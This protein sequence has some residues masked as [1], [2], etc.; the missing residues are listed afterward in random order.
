M[1]IEFMSYKLS[2]EVEFGNIEYKKELLINT[3]HK[4]NKLGTQMLY[5]LY[6]GFG[7]VIY[8]LGVT[9]DGEIVG[10][11]EKDLS[12]SFELLQ[13]V[14]KKIDAELIHFNKMEAK[15][16]DKFYMKIVFKKTLNNLFDF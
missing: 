7:Y 12:K 6:Q 14:S 4:I 2:P 13:K 8:Y 10:L 11:F 5:R 15:D 9:D 16:A 3:D 1:N